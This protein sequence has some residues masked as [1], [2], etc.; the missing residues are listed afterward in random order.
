MCHGSTFPSCDPACCG[1]RAPPMPLAL[2]T[3]PLPGE[4]PSGEH[5]H[6]DQG[7]KLQGTEPSCSPDGFI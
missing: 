5:N 2:P 6:G 4:A 3:L 1:G 7:D